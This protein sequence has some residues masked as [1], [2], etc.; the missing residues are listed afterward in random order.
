[1]VVESLKDA[2][3]LRPR[4]EDFVVEDR[5]NAKLGPF[6][7]KTLAYGALLGI[8]GYVV[9]SVLGFLK[10]PPTALYGEQNELWSGF[11]TIVGG[12]FCAL[13][14]F[15]LPPKIEKVR[16]GKWVFAAWTVAVLALLIILANLY[17]KQKS[18]WTLSLDNKVVLVGDEYT[19]DAQR[20][21]STPGKAVVDIFKDFGYHSELVWQSA[22][23]R[24]RNRILGLLY[25][26]VVAT[27]GIFLSMVTRFVTG[28][29]SGDKET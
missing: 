27:G 6:K 8:G 29:F 3:T 4:E 12:V 15:L 25:L 14:S 20:V 5:K 13:T 2:L 18:D 11:A 28:E 1:M 19:P 16:K 26:L 23:L 21:S 9:S 17:D 7:S 10:S 22:G 24:S